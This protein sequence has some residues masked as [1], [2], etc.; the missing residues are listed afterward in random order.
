MEN[1][2]TQLEPAILST[3]RLSTSIKINKIFKKLSFLERATGSEEAFGR[4][5]DKL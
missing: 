3:V 5:P 4:V 1:L 2:E